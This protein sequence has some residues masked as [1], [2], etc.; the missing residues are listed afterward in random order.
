VSEIPKTEAL[1]IEL[2]KESIQWAKETKRNFLRQRIETRL[3]SLYLDARQ[4]QVALDLI[5]TLVREVKRL[6]DKLLLVEIQLI[7]S[8][9]H[10]AL[11][12][13]PKARVRLLLELNLS[14]FRQRLQL[15]G[16]VQMPYTVHLFCKLKLICNLEYYMLKRKI[17]KQPT[18]TFMKALKDTIHWM[19]QRLSSA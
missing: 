12:N 13:L 19:T 18:P 17:I 8:R 5:N 7:E 10:H 4:F 6:D 16:Q 14:D 11:R 2:C 9:I 1:Q 3:A 15:Q